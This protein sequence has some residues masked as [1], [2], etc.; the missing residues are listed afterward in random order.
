[1]MPSTA[2]DWAETMLRARIESPHRLTFDLI[3]SRGTLAHAGWH[4]P[5]S[6]HASPLAAPSSTDRHTPPSMKHPSSPC[7]TLPPAILRRAPC[8][9]PILSRAVLSPYAQR[10]TL[11]TR[12]PPSLRTARSLSSTLDSYVQRPITHMHSGLRRSTHS[13]APPADRAHLRSLCGSRHASHRF[14]PA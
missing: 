12:R 9:A 13:R 7:C 2:R 4:P 5:P 1:M 11:S 8:A 6:R 14:Q 3:V 10:P